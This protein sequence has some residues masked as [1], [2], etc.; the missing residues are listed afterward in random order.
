MLY[1]QPNNNLNGILRYFSKNP[2]LY[3]AE[4]TAKGSSHLV[5]HNKW[6]D[7]D[8][9]FDH[10]HTEAPS[11]CWRSESRQFQHVDI[12]FRIHYVKALAFSIKPLWYNLHVIKNFTL[13]GSNSTDNF[14]DIYTHNG[15]S[16]TYGVPNVFNCQNVG[17]YNHFRFTMVDHLAD[18]NAWYFIIC[19]VEFFGYVTD[20]SLYQSCNIKRYSIINNAIFLIVLILSFL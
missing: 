14:V 6:G 7:S 13:Q 18:S 5:D 11:D 9:I 2:K 8:A 16:L 3:K 15:T 19:A 17:T 12:D 1:F 10:K 4:V 20:L